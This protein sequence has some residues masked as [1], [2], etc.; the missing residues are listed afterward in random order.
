MPKHPS[1][2]PVIGS[3]GIGK[4]VAKLI[5]GASLRLSVVIYSQNF[6]LPCSF[7]NLSCAAGLVFEKSPAAIGGLH[8]HS[9]KVSTRCSDSD[10]PNVTYLHQVVH[11]SVRA[12]GE[13]ES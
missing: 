10:S 11:P 2:D 5:H 12:I 8:L 4:I 3:L 1:D 7:V 6:V 9:N 13:V